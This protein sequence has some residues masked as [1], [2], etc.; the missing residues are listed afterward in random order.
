LGWWKPVVF[1]IQF[2]SLAGDFMVFQ[3]IP[4][5]GLYPG[6]LV[7]VTWNGMPWFGIT[8]ERSC[9]GVENSLLPYYPVI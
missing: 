7:A 3:W 2:S 1:Q 5:Y 9:R 8:K 4:G 6:F